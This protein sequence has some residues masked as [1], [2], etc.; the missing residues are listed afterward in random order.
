[1]RINFYR[2]LIPSLLLGVFL[3]TFF[4]AGRIIYPFWSE[5]RFVPIDNSNSD[6]VN[7]LVV[8]PDNAEIVKFGELNKYLKEHKESSFTIPND[9]LENYHQK[10]FENFQKANLKSS[11]SLKVVQLSSNRQ[12]I[13]LKIDG[14]RRN[15][16]TRYEATEKEI[17]LKTFLTENLFT[18]L[19]LLLIAIGI[20]GLFTLFTYLLLK[21]FLITR[22]LK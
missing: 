1:M 4:I 17:F 16:I 18:E 9:K 10:L 3:S 12:S 21:R 13:E 7:I 22:K 19:P 8:T 15:L 14:N 5:S 2:F 6:L 11:L 20:G